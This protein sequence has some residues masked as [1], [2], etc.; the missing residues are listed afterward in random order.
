MTGDRLSLQHNV[1]RVIA[2]KYELRELAGEGGMATVWRARMY[3]AAGFSREVAVKKMKAEFRAIK[4]YIDMFVEE[5][6]VGSDL[7]HPNIVQVYDFCQDDEKSYYLVMEWV[8]GVDF[9]SFVRAFRAQGHPIPWPLVAAIGVGV[10]RGL[11]AAHER[12]G[13]TGQP[14]PVIH[15]DVSPQ[16]ILL[17]RDGIVKLSDFGLARAMDRIHSLT[18]PGTVKG[19]LSYLAPEITM[20]RSAT[21][22][23]DLFSAGSVLWEGLAGAPLFDGERDVDVF[24]KIRRGEVR[25]IEQVRPDVPV[26]LAQV[27]HRALA[28]APR[29]RF[30]SARQMANELASVLATVQSPTD[31]QTLLGRAVDCARQWL[32]GARSTARP[33]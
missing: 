23:S 24:A 7:Q 1:G 33:R 4:N 25:P 18:A 30:P 11:A 13:P 8:D 19:K 10:L 17:R 5:A 9:G 14:A 15:R 16:N 2:G 32:G 6:R 21:V 28:V 26:A 12:R 3:G 27:V 31:A 22:L 20:G 29:E